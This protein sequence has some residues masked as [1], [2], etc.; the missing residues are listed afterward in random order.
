[1]RFLTMY[2]PDSQDP[3]SPEH[4]AVMGEFVAAGFR[5]GELVSTGGL[6]AGASRVRSSGG[7]LSVTDGPFAESKEMVAGYAI[8]EASSE[9]HAIEM[10]K[11]F[12]EVAGDGV[13]E[14]HRIFGPEDMP[15]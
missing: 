8:L 6:Q 9:D 14:V 12:L 11:R 7:R 1:M 2:T 4:M 5:S 10:T 15:T 13:C 3:P